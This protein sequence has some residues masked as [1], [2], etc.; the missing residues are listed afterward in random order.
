V[1]RRELSEVLMFALRKINKIIIVRGNH[2]NYLPLLRD[3]Y[4][5]DIVNEL[6]LGEILIVHGHKP[7]TEKG[8]D[9]KVVIFG[10]EH[11]SIAVRDSLGTVGKF[12][13]FLMGELKDGRKLITLPAVGAYQT[14]SK[15]TTARDTY[16]SPILRDEAIIEKLK[17]IIVDEE[18]GLFELPTLSELMDLI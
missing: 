11:P 7:I 9:W 13:C 6:K 5:F 12:P 2:D 17:P 14:G 3:K 18:I 10:H 1:E 4:Q 16:L 15:V 8:T